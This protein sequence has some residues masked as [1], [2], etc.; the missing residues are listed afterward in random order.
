[1]AGFRDKEEKA[2]EAQ[3]TINKELVADVANAI[4]DKIAKPGKKTD[5]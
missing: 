3:R 1:M 5:A 2:Q 4:A